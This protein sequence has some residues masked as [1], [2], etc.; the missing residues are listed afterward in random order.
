M[1]VKHNKKDTNVIKNLQNIEKIITIWK[2]INFLTGDKNHSTI[3]S[4]DILIDTT[5]KWND[6]KQ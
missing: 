1:D 5:I 2:I 3:Q 6:I 4:I